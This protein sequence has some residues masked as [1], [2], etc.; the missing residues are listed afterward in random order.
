MT[1]TTKESWAS[2]HGFLLAALGAS[3]GLGNVWRFSYVAGEN[4]GGAFLLVYLLMVLLI[5][6]PLLL[7]ELALGRASQRES[8]AALRTLAPTT[9]WKHVGVLGVIAASV[10][11][12]YYAVIAGWV[13]RYMVLYVGSTT[14]QLG[15]EGYANAFNAYVQQ[16]LQPLGWQLLCVVLAMLVI[17]KGVQ[18]G[19]EQVSLL[20][21]PAL[22]VLLLGLAVYGAT[23]SGFGQ[24]AA[25]LFSPDWSALLRPEVYLAALGQAFFSIGLAMGVMITYGSYL[26]LTQNLPR[27]ALTIALGDTLFAMTAG[28]MIFPAVFSYGLDPAQGPGL[29]FVV[30]PEVFAQMPGGALVGA[31]FFLLL[32]IAA[33]TSMVALLEVPVAWAMQRL[34]WSRLRACLSLGALLYLLGM[35]ASLGFGVWRDVQ[36]AGGQGILDS[37]DFVAVELLLPLSGLLLALFIGWVWAADA[38]HQASGLHHSRLGQLWRGLL[39]YLVPVLMVLVLLGSFLGSGGH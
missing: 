3:V 27:A 7:G 20:L 21:M 35:P 37:M 32:S 29:A 24:A 1:D 10:I 6:V 38:A 16:A 34:G 17:A 9:R 2:H 23:L 13:M 19:I 36:T 25:F 28:L 12:A 31:A 4:G 22:A 15:T 14:H 5:G 33:L 8:A 39:R 30:L 18:R 26:P 11:L